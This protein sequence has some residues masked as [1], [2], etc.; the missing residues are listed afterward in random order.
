VRLGVSCGGLRH[1][2]YSTQTSPSAHAVGKKLENDE[3]K[4]VR[5]ILLIK[6]LPKILYIY[7]TINTDFV[8]KQFIIFLRFISNI[9][10]LG[11]YQLGHDA[12]NHMG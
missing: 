1:I 4:T 10:F 11:I 2:F 3:E 7:C 8:N 9:R 12:V 6:I 5:T